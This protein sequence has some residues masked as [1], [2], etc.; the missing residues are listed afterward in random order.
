MFNSPCGRE[1][2]DITLRL[3]NPPNSSQLFSISPMPRIAP[4]PPK[5][6]NRQAGPDTRPTGLTISVP[7]EHRDL[8]CMQC[9]V[10]YRDRRQDVALETERK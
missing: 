3:N 8:R 9:H 10:N 7:F 2:G 6:I 4:N 5:K 1:R